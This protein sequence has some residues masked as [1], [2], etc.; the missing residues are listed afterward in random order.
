MAMSKKDY[1]LIASVFRD[2][3]IECIEFEDEVE[4]LKTVILK[5][6]TVLKK[7]NE[8][9]KVDIFLKACGVSE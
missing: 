2:E 6:A 5:L 4:T 8:A 3:L 7:D 9:F 1:V